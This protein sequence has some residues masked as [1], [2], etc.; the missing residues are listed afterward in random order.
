M[1]IELNE[2]R[3]IA[4]MVIKFIGLEVPIDDVQSVTITGMSIIVAYVHRGCECMGSRGEHIKTVNVLQND[5]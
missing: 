2:S 5:E 3:T 1:S 4:Q